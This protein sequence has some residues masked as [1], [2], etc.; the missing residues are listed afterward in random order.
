M[1]FSLLPL[2]IA[3]RFYRG[4]KNNH[5]ISLISIIYTIGITLGVAVLIISLSTI[6]S[7]YRELKSHIL[8]VIPHGEIEPVDQ[9][10]DNWPLILDKIKKVSGVQTA[11][12][13]INF[14]GL[15][16]SDSHVHAVQM[17]GI[18]PKEEN[19]LSIMSQYI[20]ADT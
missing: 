20:Q 1:L 2:F 3:F 5:I 10:F 4:H 9:P 8:M 16:K 19:K 14:T 17:K 13:Y 11:V 18:N 6:N 12:P 7:F 15:I